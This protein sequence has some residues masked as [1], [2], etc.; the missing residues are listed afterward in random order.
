MLT[1]LND[2]SNGYVAIPVIAA[3]SKQGLFAELSLTD[4]VSFQELS[5]K[6]NANKGFYASR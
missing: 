2:Y 6:L 3:C 4:P 1:I 5:G